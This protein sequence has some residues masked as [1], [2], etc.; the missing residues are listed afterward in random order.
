MVV[1]LTTVYD[2][3]F[4]PPNLTP[5]GP[6]T[7]M[8]FVPVMVTVTPPPEAVGVNE[9]TVGVGGI[10]VNPGSVANPSG[11]VTAT[12]PELPAATTAVI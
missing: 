2:A 9:L 8:K 11:L 5:A 7:S 4:V 12:E 10:Y 6:V 1:E 3:A